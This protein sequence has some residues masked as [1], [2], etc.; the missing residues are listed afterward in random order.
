MK[1]SEILNE[2]YDKR[3]KCK[4][5]GAIYS[6]DIAKRRIKMSVKFPMDIDLSEEEANNLE[7]KLHYAFEKV[8]APLF[9]KT[10]N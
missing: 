8:L 4:T 10:K 1:I 2:G 3:H 7:A 6:S 9:K 5:P